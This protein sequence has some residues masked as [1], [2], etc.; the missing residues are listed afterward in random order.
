MEFHFMRS[1]SFVLPAGVRAHN[2]REFRDALEQVSL[3]SIAFHM[4]DA[5]LRL[6]RGDNDF[7]RWLE[8]GLMNPAWRPD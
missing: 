8:I 1:I 7:S 2:L 4:F 5:R 3:N 6:E